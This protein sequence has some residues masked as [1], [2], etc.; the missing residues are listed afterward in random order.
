MSIFF[1][2]LTFGKTFLL[3]KVGETPL[4]PEEVVTIINDYS[5]Y[6]EGNRYPITNLVEMEKLEGSPESGEIVSQ[7][8]KNLLSFISI[9]SIKTTRRPNGNIVINS[10]FAPKKVRDRIFSEFG[11][12]HNSPFSSIETVWTIS[13]LESGPFQTKVEYKMKAIGNGILMW[14]AQ[15]IIK[16]ELKNVATQLLD[17]IEVQ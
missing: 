11:I 12:N 9:F 14:T 16:S 5:S 1:S 10:K 15:G 13:P 3:N 7:K 17:I 6:G 8:V 2:Q 4:T